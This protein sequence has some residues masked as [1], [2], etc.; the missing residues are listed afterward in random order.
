MSSNNNSKR[1]LSDMTTTN[2]NNNKRKKRFD[3][4]ESAVGTVKEIYL[5]NFMCHDQLKVEFG[6][7]LNIITGRNGSGKSAILAGLQVCLG[8]SARSTHRGNKIGDLVRNDGGNRAYVSVRLSNL[9]SDAF[10]PQTYGTEIVIERSIAK[11]GASTFKVKNAFGKTVTTQ[12]KVVKLICEKFNIQVEN[13]VCILDQQSAKSFIQGKD[14]AKYQFFLKA[15]E[16]KRLEEE[17]L[18]LHKKLDIMKGNMESA[19]RGLPKLANQRNELEGKLKECAKLE[20]SMEELKT[21]E[22]SVQWAGLREKEHKLRNVENDIEKLEKKKEKYQEA[23]EKVKAR[24]KEAQEKV[25]VTSKEV[26]PDQEMYEEASEK[27]TAAKMK[28]KSWESKR[29]Q[30][31]RACKASQREVNECNMKKKSLESN[32]AEI[33]GSANFDDSNL[34]KRLEDAK[35]EQKRVQEEIEEKQK[36]IDN[37]SDRKRSVQQA[38]ITA[39]SNLERSQRELRSLKSDLRSSEQSRT[40]KV[41]KFGGTNM[42]RLVDMIEK[43]KAKFQKMP[44]GPIGMHVSVKNKKWNRAVEFVTGSMLTSFVVHSQHD[45]KILYGLAR[46]CNINVRTII[47]KFGNRN[48]PPANMIPDSRKFTTVADVVEVDNDQAWNALLD[49][50]KIEGNA[51]FDTAREA[52]EKMK[53]ARNVV[54]GVMPDG[55]TC[56][57]RNNVVS[58]FRNKSANRP[59]RYIG[60]DVKQIVADLKREIEKQQ[61]KMAPYQTALNVAKQNKQNLQSEMRSLKNELVKLERKEKACD[62]KIVAIEREIQNMRDAEDEREDPSAVRD[63]INE[64]EVELKNHVREVEKAQAE[65]QEINEQVKEAD[66]ELKQCSKRMQEIED[67]VLAKAREVQLLEDEVHNLQLRNK[68]MESKLKEYVNLSFFFG[69]CLCF[70]LSLSHTHTHTLNRN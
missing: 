18:E 62:K 50:C 12:S 14:E 52:G 46:K 23:Y 6:P 41:S 56:I 30:K 11:K 42:I 54:Q 4:K 19:K 61:N 63:E 26:E 66:Q 35:I 29:T 2:L 49:H 24:V 20:Q 55:M 7:H 44:V 17:Y 53:G 10:E 36:S 57:I 48:N 15:T 8:A 51:L 69:L 58:N 9:G 5:E 34:K 60:A 22:K 32:L 13:P 68:N 37:F 40:N 31:I 3:F 16:L 45:N 28:K 38:F 64:V 70:C 25:D 43:S 33:L 39:E 47:S 27:R 65:I 59:L 1:P 67:R 21:C